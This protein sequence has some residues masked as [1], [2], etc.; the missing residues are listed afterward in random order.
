MKDKKHK[1]FACFINGKSI[2]YH[3]KMAN[4][5]P[6]YFVI[7]DGEEQVGKTATF[8]WAAVSV[9]G[10]RKPTIKQKL[11]LIDVAYEFDKRSMACLEAMETFK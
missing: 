5:D 4:Q 10:D 3:D 1:H 2:Y 6:D 8:H 9:L 11:K 7:Y